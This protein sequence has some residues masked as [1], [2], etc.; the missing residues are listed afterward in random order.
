MGYNQIQKWKQDWKN[1]GFL[2]ANFFRI[3]LSIFWLI[4]ICPLAAWQQHREQKSVVWVGLTHQRKSNNRSEPLR[5]RVFYRFPLFKGAELGKQ[6]LRPLSSRASFFAHFEPSSGASPSLLQSFLLIWCG[7]ACSSRKN[8]AL[9][10]SLAFLSRL[11]QPTSYP[12]NFAQGLGFETC[13]PVY[14]LINSAMRVPIANWPQNTINHPK[15]LLEHTW[16][17]LKLVES[18]A[19]EILRMR[20][21]LANPRWLKTIR[22]LKTWSE[23][24]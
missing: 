16:R 1:L 13:P 10:R 3:V 2:T 8:S 7:G 19:P 11:S 23:N 12:H 18:I 22:W 15:T 20:L 5:P 9:K 17:G 21:R 14:L 4:V 24:I 6:R